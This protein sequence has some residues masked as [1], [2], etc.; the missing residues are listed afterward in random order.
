MLLNNDKL[1]FV[2]IFSSCSSSVVCGTT[3]FIHCHKCVR[4]A[5]LILFSRILGCAFIFYSCLC[6]VKKEI[7]RFA[8]H[9]HTNK[10]NAEKKTDFFAVTLVLPFFPFF[11]IHFVVAL[12]FINITMKALKKPTKKR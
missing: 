1:F 8:T 3:A 10:R 4:L 11:F 7:E 6:G 2:L 12:L 5:V 9:L